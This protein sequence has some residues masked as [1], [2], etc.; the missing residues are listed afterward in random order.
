MAVT[1]ARTEYDGR[2]DSSEAATRV[3]ATLKNVGKASFRSDEGAQILVL[4]KYGDLDFNETKTV[5]K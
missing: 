4:Y 5:D 3:T 1:D 2:T